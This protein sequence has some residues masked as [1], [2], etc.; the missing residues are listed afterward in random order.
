MASGDRPGTSSAAD[1]REI[2]DEAAIAARAAQIG[3]SCGAYS[4][5]CKVLGIDTPKS[6]KP[7]RQWCQHCTPGR[8]CGIY[9][10]RPPICR[11][12]ACAWLVGSGLGAAWYPLLSKMVVILDSVVW[13]LWSIPGLLRLA[14]VALPRSSCGG[15]EKEVRG[16]PRNSPS[17]RSSGSTEVGCPTRTADLEIDPTQAPIE[18]LRGLVKEDILFRIVATQEAR[19]AG[20][21]EAIW[22]AWQTVYRTEESRHGFRTQMLLGWLATAA[23]LALHPSASKA[24]GLYPVALRGHRAGRSPCP[25]LLTSG[26]PPM[27]RMRRDSAH[28]H[29]QLA[30]G[31]LQAS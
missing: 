18:Q 23:G 27:G 14:A 6:T 16:R 30:R 20:R 24:D 29:L 26:A 7:P 13:V 17:S 21:A 3:R 28:R 8:G 12:Y 10:T 22:N 1:R 19:E 9:E 4:L 2:L 15:G 25:P 5:C 11:N 31:S